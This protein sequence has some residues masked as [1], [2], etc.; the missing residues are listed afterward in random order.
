M[1]YYDRDKKKKGKS[2][3]IPS[4]QCQALLFPGSLMKALQ[5]DNAIF[6]SFP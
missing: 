3:G 6:L 5:D 2:Q 4:G 1:Y